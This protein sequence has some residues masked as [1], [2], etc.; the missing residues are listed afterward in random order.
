MKVAFISEIIAREFD[1]N[2]KQYGSH[3]PPIIGLMKEGVK[4]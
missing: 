3:S 1:L 2:A 4:L